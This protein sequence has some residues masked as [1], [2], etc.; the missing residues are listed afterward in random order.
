MAITDEQYTAWLRADAR[1]RVLLA[2][3]KSYKDGVEATRYISTYPFV[4][5][6]TD[7]PPNQPYD[8]IILEVPLFTQRIPEALGGRSIA[9]WGDVVFSLD[10]R[11]GDEWLTHA[12]DGREI[13]LLVG[14]KDWPRADFRTVLDGFSAD[15]VA[16]DDRRGAIR[17]RDKS[18]AFNVPIQTNR[19][20][21]GPNAGKLK[22]LALG[23]CF[24]AEPPLL[25]AATHKY[26]GHDGAAEDFPAVREGGNATAFTEQLADGTFTLT[27]AP[28]L[29]IT[30]DIK[31]E[32]SGPYLTTAA[33]L[34]EHIVTTRTVLTS[35]DIDGAS[36][37]A[38][39]ALCPQTLGLYIREGGLVV[40]ALDALVK[41]VGGFWTFDHDDLLTLGRLDLPSG[42]P[43]L[44]LYAERGDIERDG[45]QL[46]SRILPVKSERFGYRRNW[47]VQSDGLANV[48]SEADRATYGA[49]Y[50]TVVAENPLVPTT[51]L[52]A[53]EPA[54]FAT[55]MQIEAEA[56]AEVE[57]DA[58]LYSELRYVHAVKCFTAPFRVRCGQVIEITY[59]NTL[60]RTGRLVTVIG[61]RV[62]PTSNRCVLEVFS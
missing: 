51:H 10:G 40:N 23:D 50:K 46:V 5:A 14:D 60:F 59:P 8:D 15:I 54:E 7:T 41:S 53:D 6:P 17:I 21:S 47:T 62:S 37:T 36:F 1:Q 38:F 9:G 11:D 16:L 18:W 29:R 26:Q 52:L 49:A 43:V 24:N 33:G 19:I 12:W 61:K 34:I 56:Q 25:D 28:T 27:G 13:Q 2:E 48:V 55:L 42:T 44:R 35:G 3:A 4:S 20:A 31:G 57:R 22:P 32:S 30:C 58:A 45:V 39:D